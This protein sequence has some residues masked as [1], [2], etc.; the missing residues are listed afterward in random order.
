MQHR[1]VRALAA[2]LLLAAAPTVLTAPSSAAP[3]YGAK[4]VYVA[5]GDSFSAGLGADGPIDGCGRSAKGY[6]ALW[7]KAHSIASF[8]N[9]ACGGA[10]SG[11]VLGSQLSGLSAKTEVVTITLGGNDVQ[12]GDQVS[13]CLLRDDQG[14]RTLIDDFTTNLPARTAAVTEVYA[15]IRTAAP[16][17]DVYVLGYPR[18]FDTG[19][20]CTSPLTP[21]L[22]ERR[23][24]NGATDALNSV[25]AQR[26]TDAGFRFVDVRAAF[27][28]HGV[29]SSSSWINPAASFP[30]PLHPTTDGYRDGYLAALSAVTG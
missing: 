1:F 16:K 30:A 4:T 14:C 20:S 26:A 13:A 25:L 6:P 19:G 12:L 18:L 9:A 11:D 28:G 2:A 22:D 21:T 10:V 29:C 8:V 27:A 24:L 15:A 3:R 7:A 23:V 17:A 5:L